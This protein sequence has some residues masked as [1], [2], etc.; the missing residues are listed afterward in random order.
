VGGLREGE[1][2]RVAPV[3]IPE[4]YQSW[5]TDA[6]ENDMQFFAASMLAIAL[7]RWPGTESKKHGKVLRDT[8]SG[9]GLLIVEGQQYPFSLTDLWKSPQ[10]PQIGMMVEAEF[11]RDG[12]LVAIRALTTKSGGASR[13]RPAS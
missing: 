6:T 12:Q 13:S 8:S 2:G 7:F 4:C 10:P 9:S 3:R 5:P 1:R 11:N